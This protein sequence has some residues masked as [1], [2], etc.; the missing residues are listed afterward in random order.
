M[1]K[2]KEKDFSHLIVRNKATQLRRKPL[3]L[4]FNARRYGI[5]RSLELNLNDSSRDWDIFRGRETF[6]CIFQLDSMLFL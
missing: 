4:R 2:L 1:V 3:T 5:I 6:E